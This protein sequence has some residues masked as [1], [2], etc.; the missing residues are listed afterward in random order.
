[1]SETGKA[2]QDEGERHTRADQPKETVFHGNSP[3]KR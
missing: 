2:R 3:Q 1:L